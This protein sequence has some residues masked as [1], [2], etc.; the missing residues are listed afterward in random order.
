[1]AQEWEKGCRKK[2][3]RRIL[4]AAD[5]GQL[6]VVGENMRRVAFTCAFLFP[7]PATPDTGP[8][9]LWLFFFQYQ[10]LFLAA[11]NA[12]HVLLCYYSFPLHWLEGSIS[13]KRILHVKT[14]G[15]VS[16]DF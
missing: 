11:R 14:C 9:L 5:D 8:L 2:G 6:G 10:L 3:G 4:S 7:A 1:M 13:R 12:S 16:G 15:G